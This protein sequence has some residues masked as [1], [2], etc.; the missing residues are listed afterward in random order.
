MEGALEVITLAM[1]I[2]IAWTLPSLLVTAFWAVL[3]EVGRRFGNR[4]TSKR[5]AR[6]EQQLSAE[7]RAIYADFGDDERASDEALLHCE[8]DETTGS[9]AIVSYGGSPPHANGEAGNWGLQAL[10]F[11]AP[12]RGPAGDVWWAPGRGRPVTARA[13][14]AR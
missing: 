8:R 14:H 7:V 6:E 10:S 1:R 5:P 13:P 12:E 9:D 11:D 4:V 2:A 3:L